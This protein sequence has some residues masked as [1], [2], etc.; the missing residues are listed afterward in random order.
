VL[1]QSQQL[2]V[3]T[4]DLGHISYTRPSGRILFYKLPNLQ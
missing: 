1:Q 3:D 2:P 4:V